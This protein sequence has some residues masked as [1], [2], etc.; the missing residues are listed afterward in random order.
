MA[1]SE[2]NQKRGVRASLIELWSRIVKYDQVAGIYN[3]GA[4]NLYPNELERVVLNS[5]TASRARVIFSNF[6]SGKGVSNDRVVNKK[7]GYLLSY[8]LEVI[9]DDLSLHGGSYIHVSYGLNDVGELVPTDYDVLDYV[10]CRI[11]KEDDEKNKGNIVY[12]DFESKKKSMF[13]KSQGEKEIEFMPYTPNI[14]VTW[15]QIKAVAREQNLTMEDAVRAFKGQVFYL[16]LTPKYKYAISPFDSVYN[17]CDT[18]YRISLYDNGMLRNGLLGKTAVITQGLDEEQAKKV[19]SDIRQWLGVENSNGVYHLDLISAENIDNVL[20]IISIPSQ[21][22][23]DRFEKLTKRVRENILGAANNIPSVLAFAADSS[24]L[25]Q[26]GD[27]YAELKLFYNEQTEGERKALKNA[28]N[29]LKINDFE[30]I[31]IITKEEAEN[32]ESR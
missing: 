11:K 20:K 31:P 10:R 23:G 14:K 9:A 18:E 32:G 27:A 28:L 22:D 2:T 5:P 26:N 29:Y 15:E 17:D 24:L 21:Y 4:D 6:I 13:S 16:N 8:F 30:I 12:K 25:G 7:K 1:Y 3:N 19:Q